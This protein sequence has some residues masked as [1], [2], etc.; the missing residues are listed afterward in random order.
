M[1]AT[2]P[3]GAPAS[4][5]NPALRWSSDEEFAIGDVSY[6][7]KPR[8]DTLRSR[9]DRFC[10]RKPREVIERYESLIARLEPQR[11]AEVG[12][13]EGGSTAMICQIAQPERL[14]AVDIEADPNPALEQFSQAQGM[15][16]SLSVHWGVDQADSERLGSIV[17][18]D[19]GPDPLDLVIDDASHFLDESRITF[20]TL[21]PRLRPGGEYVLEDWA[22]GHALIEVWPNRQPLTV[23]V[24]ELTIACAHHPEWI[25]SIEIDR[26]WAVIRRGEGEIEPDGFSL[27]AGLGDRGRRLTDGMMSSGL[28]PRGEQ[29]GKRRW[30]R[31]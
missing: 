30:L 16:D 21:F 17:D 18:S 12:I 1:G 24:A 13:Y 7:C 9:A 3:S 25:A 15:T 19:L 23:L 11:I 5:A 8:K 6:V 4:P 14:I 26:P 10:I 31:R 27:R 22:W 2:D 20:E 29:A 28:I